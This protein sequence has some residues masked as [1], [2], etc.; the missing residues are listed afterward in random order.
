M[1]WKKQLAHW[2]KKTSLRFIEVKSD[3]EK[4]FSHFSLNKIRFELVDMIH[5]TFYLKI[6]YRKV[7]IG[8]VALNES[9]MKKNYSI[10][11]DFFVSQLNI[12]SIKDIS[13]TIKILLLHLINTHLLIE[14]LQ[15]KL[16]K[17]YQ[18]KRY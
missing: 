4:I 7:N 9:K 14:I 10:R 3:L 6:C 5:F 12:D 15:F 2:N 17:I 8:F 1:V 11:G 16:T 18:L 13:E